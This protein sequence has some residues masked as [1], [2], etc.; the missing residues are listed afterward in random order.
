MRCLQIVK[1]VSERCCRKSTARSAS[2]DEA[3]LNPVLN[4]VSADATS[5]ETSDVAWQRWNNRNRL[6]APGGSGDSDATFFER[7]SAT[8]SARNAAKG[9]SLIRAWR[10]QRTRFPE[11]TPS[12]DMS[13]LLATGFE[14]PRCDYR[15]LRK[16]LSHC[17]T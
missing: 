4:R 7:N 6:N 12:C 13:V 11:S 14:S 1:P 5:M 15:R 10:Q 3:V 17:R 2:V 9:V 16:P 8:S